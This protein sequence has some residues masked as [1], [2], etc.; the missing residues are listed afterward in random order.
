MNNRFVP[1]VTPDNIAPDPSAYWFVF[2]GTRLLVFVHEDSVSI[3]LLKNL[4]DIAGNILRKHY[5]GYI[6]GEKDRPLGEVGAVSC[7]AA[8]LPN[9]IDAPHGMAFQ[10]LRKVYGRLDNHPHTE[11]QLFSIAGRA[12]QIIDWDRTH[13]FC[14]RCATP[15]HTQPHE[16]A[17]K[18]PNC[19]LITYPK[20]TPAIIVQITRIHKGERQILLARGHRFPPDWYSVIAGFVEP[21]ETLEECVHREVKEEVGVDVKDVRYFGSQPWPFPHSL[22]VGFTAVYHSG[23]IILEEAEIADARWFNRHNLPKIPSSISIARS[24]IDD[25]IKIE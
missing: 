11:E 21:G 17:K 25:F 14:S 5:L 7:Y 19:E 13:Q 23:D 24:L 1:Q 20:L 22:M 2:R 3:P 4:D 10:D 15:T 6:D 18:C 12:I 16:R 9:S 8:E